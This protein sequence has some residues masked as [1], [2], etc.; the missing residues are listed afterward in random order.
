MSRSLRSLSGAWTRHTNEAVARKPATSG[1]SISSVALLTF[2]F[3]S[4]SSQWNYLSC[5][6]EKIEN[7]FS[8]LSFFFWFYFYFFL[9]LKKSSLCKKH[10]HTNT[11]HTQRVLK[12]V[13]FFKGFLIFHFVF[14][15]SFRFLKKSLHLFFKRNLQWIV[16]SHFL[17]V[18]SERWRMKKKRKGK[19]A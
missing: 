11:H 13:I 6:E 5:S 2:P 8:F 17:R 18:Q 9:A 14:F 16:A 12:L 3:H 15:F 4:L 1:G 10:T 7:P 19:K